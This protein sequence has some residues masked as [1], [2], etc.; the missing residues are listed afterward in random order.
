MN[1]ENFK[2]AKKIT[3]EYRKI[4]KYFSKDFYNDYVDVEIGQSLISAANS[5]NSQTIT[6]GN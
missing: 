2:W 4:R 5:L 6:N 3:D 1:D